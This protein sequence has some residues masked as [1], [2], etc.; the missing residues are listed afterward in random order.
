MCLNNEI[1]DDLNVGD[2]LYITHRYSLTAY[3]NSARSA[4]KIYETEAGNKVDWVSRGTV[5]INKKDSYLYS[6]LTL[7]NENIKYE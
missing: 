1:E 4:Y 5:F 7:H 6:L 2:R 3:S